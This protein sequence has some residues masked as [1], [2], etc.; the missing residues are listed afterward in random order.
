MLFFWHRAYPWVRGSS[1]CVVLVLWLTKYTR[2]LESTRLS[3]IDE[4]QNKDSNQELSR[5]NKYWSLL[6]G[7]T[8]QIITS[9]DSCCKH[10]C[11][12]QAIICDLCEK[13]T[14]KAKNLT[15]KESDSRLHSKA[16]GNKMST[17][18]T[19][20][21]LTTESGISF[22]PEYHQIGRQLVKC[23]F[24]SMDIQF[25]SPQEPKMR[26]G[27][28]VCFSK[29]KGGLHQIYTLLIRVYSI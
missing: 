13:Q 25:W 28:T 27:G 23:P 6:Y 21:K 16:Y 1:H 14:V 10:R 24:G 22:S 17:F 15:G 29:D 2:S 18:N 12:Q 7:N 11:I 9:V 26:R 19:M 4:Q 3:K 20:P 8:F 5:Q